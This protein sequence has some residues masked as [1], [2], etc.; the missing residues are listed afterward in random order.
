M[1]RNAGLTVEM[2]S[3][4]GARLRTAAMLR[5]V[6]EMPAFP[7]QRPGV[8]YLAEGGQET[9]VMYKFGHDLPDFAMSPCSKSRRR[10]P[11]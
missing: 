4:S 3:S 7:T 9:E 10:S 2:A 1:E 5:G 8:F 6:P 11:I